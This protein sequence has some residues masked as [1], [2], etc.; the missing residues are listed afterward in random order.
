V[1]ARRG[2]HL[3]G[4]ATARQPFGHELT[5]S[6]IGGFYETYHHIGYGLLESVYAPA[7]HYELESRGLIVDREVWVDVLYKGRPIAKQRIDMIVNH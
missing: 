1:P 4:M 3:P 7:L 6:I 2:R 5:H